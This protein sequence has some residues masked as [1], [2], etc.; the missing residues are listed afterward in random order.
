MVT[1]QEWGAHGPEHGWKRGPV[2]RASRRER[3]RPHM[4]YIDG[5]KRMSQVAAVRATVLGLIQEILRAGPGCEA[6][7]TRDRRNQSASSPVRVPA[8]TGSSA[9]GKVTLT[10]SLLEPA[11]SPE[12]VEPGAPATADAPTVQRKLD[13]DA[14]EP[15]ASAAAPR[16]SYD[17]AS[18]FG[19]AT[20]EPAVPVQRQASSPS[21]PAAVSQIAAQGV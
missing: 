15:S 18:L 19:R 3:K 8:G 17:L 10:Q 20:R 14:S 1:G 6:G 13:H 11:P 21:E 9:V 7:M 4:V 5:E 12:R 16:P 2:A